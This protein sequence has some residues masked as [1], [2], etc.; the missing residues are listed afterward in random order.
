MSPTPEPEGAPLEPFA[1]PQSGDPSPAPPPEPG[2]LSA[3]DQ[4]R[5]RR[6]ALAAHPF[7]MTYRMAFMGDLATQGLITLGAGAGPVGLFTSLGSFA[8]LAQLA[9]L[10]FVERIGKKNLIF[11]TQALALLVSLPLLWFGGLQSLGSPWGWQLALLSL[12]VVTLALVCGNTAWWPLLH[13]FVPRTRTGRFFSVL[14]TIW[15]LALIGFFLG[16]TWWL[17]RAPGDFSPLFAIAWVCGLL[18]ILLL[19][20][21]PERPESEA[22]PIRELF[23]TIYR[24]AA[25]R[26]YVAGVTLDQAVFRCVPPFTILM[27]RSEAKL[28]EHEVMIATVANF[29]GGMLALLPSGWLVDRLGPRPVL[30]WTS[31][32]RGLIVLGIGLAG[33]TLAGREL[34]LAAGGLIMLW[35]FLVSAFGV[36]EV[37]VLFELAGEGNPTQLIVGSVVTR[38]V[39]AGVIALILGVAL[40]WLLALEVSE[41]LTLYLGLFA[42]LA[43]FQAGAVVPFRKLAAR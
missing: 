11:V 12:S 23:A 30:I 8:A 32:L 3:E 17:A 5:G 34:I 41:P 21:A 38:A 26:R 7:S 19:W 4:R 14:R 18:R 22:H 2:E 6:L 24:T 37:K 42:V 43:A 33:L 9:G 40:E 27:L 31:V 39:F 25:L 13:G 15:H 20:R 10:R 29:V 28:E 16:C 1:P 35:S 36:A